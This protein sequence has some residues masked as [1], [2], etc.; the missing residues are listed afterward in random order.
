M[1]RY[2]FHFQSYASR[3][4]LNV[5]ILQF[6]INVDKLRPAIT[7][8]D[9]LRKGQPNDQT[10]ISEVGQHET[11]NTYCREYKIIIVAFIIIGVNLLI[12]LGI[13]LQ[14]SPNGQCIVILLYHI[15]WLVSDKIV[16]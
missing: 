5:L 14:S 15:L 13:D 11:G 10:I 2:L 6:Q 1:D 7:I 4:D 9:I 3:P 12:Y 8:G 16:C